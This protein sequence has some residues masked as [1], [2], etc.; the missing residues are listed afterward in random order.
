MALFYCVLNFVI[1]FFLNVCN[2]GFAGSVCSLDW[3][4]HGLFRGCHGDHSRKE[5]QGPDPIDYRYRGDGDLH[6]NMAG[7]EILWQTDPR[8]AGFSRGFLL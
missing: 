5:S 1:F 8:K 3:C 7:E 4:V 2:F 6:Y